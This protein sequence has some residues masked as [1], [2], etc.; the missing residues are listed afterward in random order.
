MLRDWR[1]E[2]LP[3]GTLR[4][5][6]HPYGGLQPLSLVGAA[7]FIYLACTVRNRVYPD[8][9]VLLIGMMSTFAVM[10]LWHG[11]ATVEYVAGDNFLEQRRFFL[12]IRWRTRRL[13]GATLQGVRVKADD[14]RWRLRAVR[15]GVEIGSL[16]FGQNQLLPIGELLARTTGWKVELCLE[17]GTAVEWPS[18]DRNLVFGPA[19]SPREGFDPESP[20]DFKDR[21][22]LPLADRKSRPRGS[23]R[24]PRNR[25]CTA[26]ELCPEVNAALRDWRFEPRPEDNLC[27]R[28]HPFGGLHVPSL[29]LAVCFGVVGAGLGWLFR[30]PAFAE[31]RALF[32]LLFGGMGV[33]LV[34]TGASTVDYL[35]GDNFLEQRRYLCGLCW[36]RRRL[37]GA[38]LEAVRLPG[39]TDRWRLRAVRKGVEIGSV[40][41]DW[42]QAWT[43]AQLLG[44]RTGWKLRLYAQDEKGQREPLESPFLAT[45]RVRRRRRGSAPRKRERS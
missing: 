37:L 15:K 31:A 30:N 24:I 29:G 41:Y 10:L 28:P 32:G 35:A 18:T 34:L 22:R 33:S 9:N 8:A 6:Q 11:G 36:R 12:G 13:L 19:L 26:A 20:P 39:A 38:S 25:L 14:D 40:V 17:N 43:I 16:V 1:F 7:V 44:R 21:S 45:V 5:R 23:V 3:D 4:L 27:L 2:P 42:S